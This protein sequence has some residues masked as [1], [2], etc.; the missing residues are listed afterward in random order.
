MQALPDIACCEIFMAICALCNTRILLHSRTTREAR[1]SDEEMQSQA[2]LRL[3]IPSTYSPE[4]QRLST[5][6]D[7]IGRSLCN[8]CPRCFIRYKY[9]PTLARSQATRSRDRHWQS[10]HSML[11]RWAVQLGREPPKRICCREAKYMQHTARYGET[12]SSSITDE[13]LG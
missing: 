6:K 12:C 11:P 1:K 3:L 2:C 5:R 4:R 10:L 7:L 13:R 8:F 9:P